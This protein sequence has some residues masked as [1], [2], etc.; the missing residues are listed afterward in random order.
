MNEGRTSLKV[1]LAIRHYYLCEKEV[2]QITVVI[3]HGVGEGLQIKDY[4]VIQETQ[5]SH[6]ESY[7]DANSFTK[8]NDGT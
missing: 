3:R 2:P 1:S 6:Q 4:S 8:M 7:S 5:E